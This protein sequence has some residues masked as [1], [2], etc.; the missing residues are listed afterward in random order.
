M[1]TIDVANWA[2]RALERWGFP[3]VVALIFIYIL[4]A[5][6]LVPLVDEHRMF[7]RELSQTQQELS[8][9]MQEQTRLIR[10]LE[11]SG[12]LIVPQGWQAQH[13]YDSTE[14]DN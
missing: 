3:V 14:A 4:R 1:S 2:G 5:D 11:R 9:A 10:A 13:D 12:T 7:L 8:S 6:V